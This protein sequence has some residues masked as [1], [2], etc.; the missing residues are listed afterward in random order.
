MSQRLTE[1]KALI[2]EESLKLV[3]ETLDD[4]IFLEQRLSELRKLPFI[5]VHPKNPLLQRNTPAAKMYKELLQ[6]YINCLKM[7]EYVI[8]KE[9]RLDGEE[10]EES[11]LRAY[12]RSIK[13][14]YE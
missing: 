10:E 11:P 7:I 12:L 4:I 2:P 3:E 8:Y 5:E 6:Q 9:K 13:Q 14:K 1:L